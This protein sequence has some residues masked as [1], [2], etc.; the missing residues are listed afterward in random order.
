MMLTAQPDN[1]QGL[2]VIGMMGL[3]FQLPTFLTRVFLKVSRF[4]SQVDHLL[5]RVL[6]NVIRRFLNALSIC[7]HVG[8]VLFLVLGMALWIPLNA[9]PPFTYFFGAIAV[10]AHVRQ[11]AGASLV[12]TKLPQRLEL[13]A[14]SAQTWWMSSASII[15]S[16]IRNAFTSTPSCMTGVI[17][18]LA[19]ETQAVPALLVEVKRLASKE[20][21]AVRTPLRI[22][23][24]YRMSVRHDA[25]ISASD[26]YCQGES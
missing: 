2:G 9:L 10:L 20:L 5:S 13:L 17:A 22:V 19:V 12:F 26:K 11:S 4:D 21:F 18:R 16:T 6:P 23:W 25:I 24:P 15:G 7:C 14:A 8:V 3:G 1:F